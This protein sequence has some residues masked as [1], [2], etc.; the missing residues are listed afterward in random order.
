VKNGIGNSTTIPL[1]LYIK[2]RSMMDDQRQLFL[3]SG[4]N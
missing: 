2:H 1:S 4:D 3:P